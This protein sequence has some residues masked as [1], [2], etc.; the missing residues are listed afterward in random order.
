M[1]E[2]DFRK[3]QRLWTI[4]GQNGAYWFVDW[5]LEATSGSLVVKMSRTHQSSPCVSVW[6]WMEHPHAVSKE[7]WSWQIGSCAHVE[8]RSWWGC[9]LMGWWRLG[10]DGEVEE[11][12][13]ALKA[14]GQ[15]CLTETA[16]RDVT[17]LLCS[18]RAEG[19]CVPIPAKWFVQLSE[20]DLHQ[21]SFLH[22]HFSINIPFWS[23]MFLFL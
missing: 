13:S 1:L 21:H 16:A 3:W 10:G 15:W 9:W 19:L 14:E 22:K 18:W 2:N 4:N 8:S 6:P 12:V 7:T 17:V 5:C 23:I 20:S 11:G